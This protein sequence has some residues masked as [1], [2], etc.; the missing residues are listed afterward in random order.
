MTFIISF[1]TRANI[2]SSAMLDCSITSLYHVTK[3]TGATFFFV[4]QENL[5]RAR[6]PNGRA[7]SFL[8]GAGVALRSAPQ[9]WRKSLERSLMQRA[10]DCLFLD[11]MRIQQ[12]IRSVKLGTFCNFFIFDHVTFIQFKICCCVQNFMKIG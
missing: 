1:T 3:S 8:V 11:K 5:E 12:E 2:V 6:W 7:P 10:S 4:I 9:L